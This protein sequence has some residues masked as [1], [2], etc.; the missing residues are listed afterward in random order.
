M[1]KYIEYPFDTVK[2]RL[3]SQQVH[4]AEETGSASTLYYRGMVDCFRK[5]IC[6]EGP[7]A[8]YRGTGPNLARIVPYA[9]VMF[10]TYETTKKTLRIMSDR[11]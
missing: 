2:K 10:S 6:D 11:A 8:L 3:Q 5:V 4:L 1:G 7:L 9:A